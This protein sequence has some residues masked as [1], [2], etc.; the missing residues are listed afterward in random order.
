MNNQR[1]LP[2]LLRDERG[3]TMVEFALAFPVLTMMIWGVFQFGVLLNGNAGMQHALG[4]G[5]RL[6]TLCLNPTTE[7][8]C[9]APT[10]AQILARVSASRFGTGYGTF[11]TPTIAPG[12][13]GTNSRIVTVTYSMPLNFIFFVGPTVTMQQSK[14]IYMANRAAA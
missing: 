1:L 11:G 12:P 14:M 10:D 9:A 8:G 6:A 4:E 7:D 3:A 5:A 2:R 13:A